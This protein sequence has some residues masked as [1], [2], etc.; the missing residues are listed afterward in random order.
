MKLV[1][2]FRSHDLKLKSQKPEK[3]E[4]YYKNCQK[5]I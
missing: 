1:E 5:I 3:L 4:M 2:I